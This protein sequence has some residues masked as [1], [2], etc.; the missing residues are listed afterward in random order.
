[1]CS[2]QEYSKQ[3]KTKKFKRTYCTVEYYPD[4]YVAKID[5]F[6]DSIEMY[7]KKRTEEVFEVIE[8]KT[9]KYRKNVI[10]KISVEN[11]KSKLFNYI[12]LIFEM[13]KLN[14]LRVVCSQFG[15]TLS[16]TNYRL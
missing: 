4:D 2:D 1:M 5:N 9:G 3:L 15:D 8:C 11:F 10:L 12:I 6:R 13:V 16:V 14:T 7:F